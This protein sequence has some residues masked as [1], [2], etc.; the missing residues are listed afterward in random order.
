MEMSFLAE[1]SLSTS[2]VG[3][4]NVTE[5]IAG[6]Y[7]LYCG[8]GAARRGARVVTTITEGHFFFIFYF[9]LFSS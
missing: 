1:F 9:I 2:G 6:A 8:R 4:W 7:I 3:L 5:I